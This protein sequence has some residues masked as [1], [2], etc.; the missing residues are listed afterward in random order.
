MIKKIAFIALF[1]IVA[2]GTFSRGNFWFKPSFFTR[3]AKTSSI[4]LQ[5]VNQQI[6]TEIA[7]SE[8]LKI[9]SVSASIH[10]SEGNSQKVEAE[11]SGRSGSPLTLKTEKTSTGVKIWIDR[12]NLPS[13]QTQNLKLNIS[14]PEGWKGDL[15]LNSVSGSVNFEQNFHLEA[16]QAA[17]VSG[18]INL[19]ETFAP[20]INLSSISGRIAADRL[21]T[22]DASIQTTSGSIAIDTLESKKFWLKSI[23]GSINMPE[24]SGEGSFS[25]S[26]GSISAHVYGESRPVSMQ[27]VSGSVRVTIPE[28]SDYKVE[29]NSVSGSRN[30]AGETVKARIHEDKNTTILAFGAADQ[31]LSISS[32]SGSVSLSEDN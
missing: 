23:S 20:S 5:D 13:I 4:L 29:L 22:E 26:S 9:E 11:L 12:N 15:S 24:I 16:V 19:K 10:I 6:S 21:E 31:K 25:T 14:L 7:N 8:S 18:S 1:V 27:T 32:V 30:L 17:T 2:I 28:N 3:E